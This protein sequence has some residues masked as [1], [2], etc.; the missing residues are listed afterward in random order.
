MCVPSSWDR[1]P[2]VMNWGATA[3]IKLCP[4]DASVP[5]LLFALFP[6]E[7]GST[8]LAVGTF[9]L[10]LF[11]HVPGPSRRCVRLFVLRLPRVFERSPE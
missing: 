7:R 9:G 1:S 11:V 4:A 2:E 3:A 6:F 10:P 8:D 5:F